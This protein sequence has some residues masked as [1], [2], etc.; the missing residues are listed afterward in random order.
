MTTA[1]RNPFEIRTPLVAVCAA[2]VLA[3]AARAQVATED[4]VLEP[5]G[6]F[7]GSF[8]S[9]VA[10]DGERLAVGQPAATV[11][12]VSAGRVLVFE[13]TP[14]GW[15]TPVVVTA[16][17]AAQGMSFGASVDVEG[18]RLIVGAPFASPSFGMYRGAV[19]VFAR[20]SNGTWAF[21]AKLEADNGTVLPS[22]GRSIA[23]EGDRF[24]AGA[25]AGGAAY[26]FER[27]VT[28]TWSQL[29]RLTAPVATAA[30]QFGY[31]VAM[32]GARIVVGEP[33]ADT[34]GTDSGAAWAFVASGGTFVLDG[35]LAPGVA[36][37]GDQFG[38]DVALDGARAVVGAP[39]ANGAASD[40][41]EVHVVERSMLGTWDL[42]AS[43][44]PSLAIL[45]GRFGSSVDVRGDRVLA[46]GN[47]STGG[48]DLAEVFVR[49]ASGAWIDALR[50]GASNRFSAIGQPKGGP[51]ASS[52]D[53]LVVGSPE[54]D[55]Y[56]PLTVNALGAVSI[57]EQRTLLHG[58][59]RLSLTGANAGGGTP[60]GATHDL[61]L[62]LGDS[63][64]GALYFIGGSATGTG[65]TPLG[66]LLV[67]LTYDAY[68]ELSLALALPM[69]G[70]IGF[71]D[72]HGRADAL[73]TL[74][75][76]LAASFAGTT[77]HHAAIAIDTTTFA[78]TV[79]NAAG[80]TLFP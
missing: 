20:Q 6:L 47:E 69:V 62:R 17:D 35:E 80:V 53:R 59:H 3:S 78:S 11:G 12:F 57:F 44:A 74:P 36:A 61:L 18:D 56:P 27:S 43:L 75:A 65:P 58:Q 51:V 13:H 25:H 34:T 41:G 46:S 33:L 60:T 23:L 42:A 55:V 52:A 1:R 40:S 48:D 30:G 67:P 10:I 50:L 66:S 39:Y 76:G 68:S 26:V 9:S 77:L 5:P 21:E 28:G 49:S 45:Q 71:L 8:G 4:A 63:W 22:L 38:F 19:Y 37:A 29:V 7:G 31:A 15:S 70:Q 32:S 64:S 14:A 79:T 16:P 54:G 72:T 24:V 2:L 73:F